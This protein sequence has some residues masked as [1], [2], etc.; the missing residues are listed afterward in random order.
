VDSRDSLDRVEKISDLAGN[1]EGKVGFEDLTAVVMKGTVFW[2]ITPCSSLK[3]KRRFGGT[4]R[5]H[6]QVRRESQAR[7]KRESRWQAEVDEKPPNR[8]TLCKI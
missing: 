5:F 7:H 4:Y 2:D 1:Q 6:L 3:V 8:G